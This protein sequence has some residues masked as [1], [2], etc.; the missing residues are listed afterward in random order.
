MDS[1]EV[2]R[3]FYPT[4]QLLRIEVAADR[5][6]QPIKG[7]GSPQGRGQIETDQDR[8]I[9]EQK[10]ARTEAQLDAFKRR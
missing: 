9:E 10:D 8:R 7:R 6:S 1:P 5:L 2:K 3:W 4:L